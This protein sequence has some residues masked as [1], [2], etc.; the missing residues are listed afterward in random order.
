MFGETQV[1]WR[2]WSHFSGSGFVVTGG[3]LAWNQRPPSLILLRFASYRYMIF[4]RNLF[5]PWNIH[6]LAQ[7]GN[8]I[9][10]GA[11]SQKNNGYVRVPPKC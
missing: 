10:A 3:S 5:L 8:I 2:L 7:N 11:A 9:C 4:F 1:T 6:S